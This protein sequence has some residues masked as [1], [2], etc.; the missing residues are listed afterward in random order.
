MYSL[1]TLMHASVMPYIFNLLLI[2]N[3]E[4]ISFL[5]K[6]NNNVTNKQKIQIS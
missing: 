2:A 6:M 1:C 5:Y 4:K 3:L